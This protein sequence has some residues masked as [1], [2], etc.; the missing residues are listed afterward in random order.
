MLADPEFPQSH[1]AKHA[2]ICIISFAEL[3]MNPVQMTQ[4]NEG[5]LNALRTGVK[6]VTLCFSLHRNQLILNKPNNPSPR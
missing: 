4:E 2:L 3:N 6:I 5:L 1:V